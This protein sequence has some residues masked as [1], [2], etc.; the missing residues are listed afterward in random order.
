MDDI[1]QFVN[2]KVQGFQNLV[3]QA[4]SAVGQ[5]G[6]SLQNA[7][8]QIPNAISGVVRGAYPQLNTVK[9]QIDQIS[10]FIGG[11]PAALVKGTGGLL[12]A[13]SEG[14]QGITKWAGKNPL[15]EK[16]PTTGEPRVDIKDISNRL[17]FVMGTT[18]AL[19]STPNALDSV[20]AKRPQEALEITPQKTLSEA[21]AR[22]GDPKPFTKDELSVAKD[23]SQSDF[24]KYQDLINSPSSRAKATELYQ[25]ISQS[26]QPFQN[27][28]NE[29]ASEIGARNIMENTG[30]K[31]MKSMLG[32]VIDKNAVEG[33]EYTLNDVQDGLRATLAVPDEASVGKVAQR[34]L[35][36]FPDAKV[37]DYFKDPQAGYRGYHINAK[38]PNGLD[39]EL[40]V[41]TPQS[42]DYK[43][44]TMDQYAKYGYQRFSQMPEDVRNKINAQSLKDFGET[45]TG[46][47]VTPTDLTAEQKQAFAEAAK[48]AGPQAPIGGVRQQ[49]QDMFGGPTDLRTIQNDLRAA[50]GNYDLTKDTAIRNSDNQISAWR[51]IP[52]DQHLEFI[53]R[54][55]EGKPQPTEELQHLADVYRQKFDTDYQLAQGLKPNLPYRADYFTQSGIWKN[56]QQAEQF[57]NSF[58]KQS[59][60]GAPGSLETRSFPTIYDGIKAGLELKETNPEILYLNNH[61]QLMKA[62]MAQNFLDEQLAKGANPDMVRK[63]LDQYLDPGLSRNPIFRT[64]KQANNALNSLQLSLSGF[65]IGTTSVNA[66]V[67]K[68]SLGLNQALKGIFQGDIG[69]TAEGIKNVVTAPIAPL[70]YAIRGN[71][72]LTDVKN[73]ITNPDALNIAEGGGRIT[74]SETYQLTGLR[75]ALDNIKNG[76]IGTKVKGVF[77]IPGAILKGTTAPIMEWY[78]PRLKNGAAA[79]LINTNLKALGEDATPEAI[80]DV[81]ARAID[82]IDNRFGQMVQDN[83]FWNKTMRDLMGLGMRSS[84]WNIGTFR[85]L[86]GGVA[87]LFNVTQSIPKLLGGQGISDRAAYTLSLP[88]TIGA[89]GAAYMYLK[90]G[91]GPQNIT[92][93]FY[94]RTGQTDPNTGKEERVSMPSYMKDVYAFG[95][96]PGQTI[97][98]KTSPIIN[99]VQSQIQNRDYYGNQ[100]V[101]PNAPFLTQAKQRVGEQ[102]INALP[103]SLQSQNNRLNPNSETATESF[104]GIGKAPASVTGGY[105]DTKSQI[106]SKLTPQ[107]QNIL[108]YL[109]TS[110]QYGGPSF[111]DKAPILMKNPWAIDALQQMSLAANPKDTLWSLPKDKLMAYIA[112]SA[113]TNPQ[114]KASLRVQNP[115]IPAFQQQYGQQIEQGV[116]QAQQKQAAAQNTPEYKLKNFFGINP[117]PPTTPSQPFNQT[118]PNPMSMLSPQ[119]VQVVSAYTALPQN[120]PQRKQLLAAN[121]WLSSYWQANQ[122]YYNQNPVQKTDPLSN[123]LMSQG[124]NP[125]PQSSVPKSF[126]GGGY[127]GYN[128]LRP[129]IQGSPR[130]QLRKMARQTFRAQAKPIKVIANRPLKGKGI[131][132]AKGKMPKLKYV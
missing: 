2:S 100:F 126:S 5:A 108:T 123:Y 57:Y 96:N 23:V 83:L 93:Y 41:H 34:V 65:H 18:G 51:Q 106:M 90:T 38:L 127:G 113:A 44:A 88:I 49:V 21:Q 46:E 14:P 109:T 99:A 52:K 20:L 32:K 82:S 77:Q 19:E 76:D 86:G 10:N 92:D 91:H 132:L 117:P 37:E 121:P 114:V 94:P 115:W 97:L 28:L 64:V 58:V 112:Y 13:A 54:I 40:Q 105:Y 128:P 125:S 70:E 68:S 45:P 130:S 120:S 129:F 26:Y 71:K 7:G 87:D 80:R 67:S 36:D 22:L 39:F 47:P 56:P 69:M 85:E 30:I 55:Q 27:Y 35:S 102:V 72:I 29:I 1:Q 50:R 25:Q 74:P 98:N 16:D 78:V 89:M 33:S 8:D 131:K 63:V 12:T 15:M 6:Q 66:I 48:T 53:Q 31:T 111:S 124:I 103:F 118:S 3:S 4:A 81:K 60:G 101:D 62:Q 104:F 75:Q 42:L 73:G 24:N 17:G 11:I 84:G 122:N 95:T 43:F 116:Q 9:P 79:D 110:S 59:L 119:Q 107:Q 61:V